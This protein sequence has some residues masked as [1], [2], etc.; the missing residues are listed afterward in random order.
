MI[1]LVRNAIGDKKILQTSNGEKTEWSHIVNLHELQE[2]EGLKAANKLSSKHINFQNNKMNV[3]LAIQT[4]SESVY[5]SFMFLLMLPDLTIKRQF[6]NCKATAEFCLN[7]NN[8]GDILNCKNKFSRHNFNKPLTSENYTQLQIHAKNFENYINTLQDETG[9]PILKTNRKTGFLGLIICLRNIFPLFDCLK[10]LGITYLLTYKLSQDFLE[11]FFS[12]IRSRGGFN[13]N[14]NALQLKSAYK[15]L[16]IRHELKE[17][18]NGNCLSD[19]LEILHVSS[20]SKM[21]KCPIANEEIEN[22]DEETLIFEHD[23]INTFW[24]LTPYIDNIVQYIA[25]YICNKL[26]KIITCD[27]CKNQLLGDKMPLLSELK[28]RG[29]YL[30]P[31]DDVYKICKMSETTIR[32]NT[33]ELRKN[34]IKQFLTITI[35]RRLLSPFSSDAMQNHILSQDVLDN[36][37]TQ[38]CKH[39]ISLYINVRLFHE[40]KNMSIKNNF[41][42]QKYTKLILFSHQ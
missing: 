16:L 19:S 5:K 25:G 42:R 11:T 6:S 9:T 13:N 39:I 18:D 33:N 4:L 1:K 26:Y 15:H 20:N 23:Y 29:P 28:N 17:F 7:F 40:A 32:Q 14:P 38:L 41:I 30:K 22:S 24:Q 8:M 36:H 35:Y 2:K 10:S 34:K 37:R 27:F 31:S 3:K 12:A 21:F